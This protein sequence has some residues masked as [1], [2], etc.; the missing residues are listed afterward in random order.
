MKFNPSHKRLLLCSMMLLTLTLIGPSFEKVSAQTITHVP[1]FTVNSIS[2][3][4]YFGASVSGAGDVNGDGQPDIIVGAPSRNRPGVSY[5]RVFSGADGSVLYTL[6]LSPSNSTQ[7]SG[8]SVSGAGDVDGDGVAD[9][10]VG[11]SGPRVYSGFDGSILYTFESEELDGLGFSVSGVGDLN[12]DGRADLFVGAVGDDN[13]GSDSGS[14]QVFSGQDGSVLFT[15]NGDSTND[16]MGFSVSGAGDVN[17]DGIPDLI[18]GLKYGGD[19]ARVFS[20]QDGSTLHTFHADSRWDGFGNAVSGAGD[21]N[22]D[23]FDDLIVGASSDFIDGT[24]VGSASVFS[25]LD[26]SLIHVFHGSSRS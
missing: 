10:I 18:A 2:G 7:S 14:A 13:N 8:R 24:E 6:G 25:G 15:F 11:A 5:S 26:G 17:N 4:D 9:L 16:G 19:Y 23:G 21:V 22:G 20:G 12:G 1:L 3:D